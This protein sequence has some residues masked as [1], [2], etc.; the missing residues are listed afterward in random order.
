MEEKL[1]LK[2]REIEP[3]HKSGITF[4]LKKSPNREGGVE[5]LLPGNK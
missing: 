1:A 4:Y 5:T 3:T 2:D